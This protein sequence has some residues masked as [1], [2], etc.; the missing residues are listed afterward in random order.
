MKKIWLAYA[1][2]IIWAWISL[3]I[4][5]G[6]LSDYMKNEYQIRSFDYTFGTFLGAFIVITAPFGIIYS[7][8]RYKTHKKGKLQHAV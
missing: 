6:L 7:Y 3:G 4:E 1:F 5:I 8:N 2:G